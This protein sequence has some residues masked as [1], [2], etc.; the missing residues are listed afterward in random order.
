LTEVRRGNTA[1]RRNS[2]GGGAQNWGHV[3][4]RGKDAIKKRNPDKHPF[5]VARHQKGGRNRRVH[6][7][8]QGGGREASKGGGKG[9]S[10]SFTFPEGSDL[11]HM[12]HARKRPGGERRQGADIFYWTDRK[13]QGGMR[14]R[15]EGGKSRCTRGISRNGITWKD[16]MAL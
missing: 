10:K 6:V 9:K 7:Q 15:G 16:K 2:W 11:P 13:K 3:I 4:F 8:W 1:E 12:I 5:R 14:K